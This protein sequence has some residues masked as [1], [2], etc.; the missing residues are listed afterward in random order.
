MRTDIRGQDDNYPT[1]PQSPLLEDGTQAAVLSGRCAPRITRC[2]VLPLLEVLAFAHRFASLLVLGTLLLPAP[3]IAQNH[4]ANLRQIYVVSEAVAR[5]RCEAE[6]PTCCC[7]YSCDVHGGNHG[8]LGPPSTGA[9]GV[10]QDC[11]VGQQFIWDY[12]FPAA[13]CRAGETFEPPYPGHCQPGPTA[14]GDGGK[15]NGN[16]NGVGNPCNP[17]TGNK[18]QVESD[19]KGNGSLAFTRYYNSQ[20][21]ADAG[22]GFG[23][24]ST[25]HKR[26]EVSGANVIV[27]QVTG[28]G[29]PFACPTSGVCAGD[30]DTKLSLN[31]DATGY[32]LIFGDGAS[33]RYDT[34]GRILLDT[35]RPGNS[36]TYDYEAGY[37]KSVIG[38]FGHTLTF[39][40]DANGHINSMTDS[41]EGLYTYEYDANNNLVRVTYPDTTFRIYHYEDAAHTHHLTGITDE[42]GIRFATFAYD[43]NGKA[44]TTEHAGHQERFTLQ[45]DSD[46]QTT[47]T[48]AANTEEVMTFAETLGFK[49][50]LSRINQTDNK[51]ITHEFDA[52]NN[53]TRAVDAEG[54]ETR[55][56]YNA[57]NQRL[58]MIEAVNT[59][60]ERTT[61][62]TYV[63]DDIDLPTE[64]VTPSVAPGQVK[65]V[66]TIYDA[67]H[68]PVEITQTGFTPNGISIARTITLRYNAKGQVIKI[69]GPRT[70]V[71][72]ITTLEYYDC[73]TG[74][75]CGQ[76]KSVTNALGHKT[77][78]DAYDANGQ[79]TQMTD[80]KGVV[81]TIT[82]D[83]RGRVTS[84][85]L[86]PPTG[87]ARITSYTYDGVGQLRT[88]T[89]PDGIILTYEY[90]DAHDLH[91][92][93]DNLHNRIEYAY[94]LRGN[95]T[96]ENTYDPD[97]TLVRSVHNAYDLRNR[98]SEINAAGSITQLV[99]DAVGNLISKTDPNAN[100]PTTHDYNALNRLQ[101]TV[102]ALGGKTGYGYDA[103]NRLIQVRAPNNA[104]TR[105]SYDDLGNLLEE[106]SPDRGTLTYT[107]DA[108]G[109][110]KSQ[111]DARGI[112]TAY[113]YDA[114]NRVIFIDDPGIE[115][116]VMFL[117]DA[118]PNGTGRLC[119]VEDQSG[120]TNY[121]YDAFG[122]V[123]QETHIELGMSYVTTYTYDA[124]DRLLSMTYPGGRIVG[125]TRDALGRV[126][127]V[128]TT[129]EG[130][131]TSITQAMSYR[132]DGLLTAQI[133]SNGLTE[134]RQ[135]DQQ[136]RLLSQSL[137][138]ADARV[139]DHDANGNLVSKQ[140]VLS[141]GSYSYDAL[142]RLTDETMSN[143][144][145]DTLAYSY[146]G[147]GNRLTR[148]ENGATEPYSYAA[149]SNRLTAI[150]GKGVTLDDA[151]NTL[152]DAQDRIFTY[153][154]TGRLS[155]VS[156]NGS[157]LGSYSYNFQGQ[158]TR[159]VTTRGTILYHYD[160]Q[161]NLIEETN[162][163]GK[164][165]SEYIW[166]NGAPIAASL[167]G[168]APGVYTFSGTDAGTGN[169]ATVDLDTEAR[170]VTVNESGGV[171]TTFQPTRWELNDTAQTL[172]ISYQTN[173]NTQ[174]N[175]SFALAES[176]PTGELS[177][178]STPRRAHYRFP[179]QPS[180]VLTGGDPANG[181][182]AILA[183]DPATR[184]VALTEHGTTRTLT[185][186]QGNW[187][188][189]GF[190]RLRLTLF[191]Y[192][193]TGFRL[194]G[195]VLER[196][197]Q[198]EGWVGLTDGTA[199]EARYALTGE[200]ASAARF[201]YLHTDHLNTPRVATDETQTVLWRWEGEAFGATAPNEDADGDHLHLTLNLR[202]PGQYADT[203]SG[204]YYN[205][206][207]YYDS[208]SGRYITSDPTG[209]FAA[210]NT[211]LY[212]RGNPHQLI[213][214]IGLGAIVGRL[215]DWRIRQLDIDLGSPFVTGDIA[216]FNPKK[217]KRRIGWFHFLVSG[218]V[219][220]LIECKEVECEQ[221][222]RRG[223]LVPS[224]SVEN[225]PLRLP[226]R[227]DQPFPLPVWLKALNGLVDVYANRNKAR[228]ILQAAA[229]ARAQAATFYCKTINAWLPVPPDWYLTEPSVTEGS[230]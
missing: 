161:G 81:T 113:S 155:Q 3:A 118:C 78:Y 98:L 140:T 128:T 83:A 87:S 16:C 216:P 215:I 229:F 163:Q 21:P 115:Q 206:M 143:G 191:R 37:L 4:A 154:T 120:T 151:G 86:T 40:H 203:E 1:G 194:L 150:D 197:T 176:P 119:A 100:P 142:D 199:R 221:E 94:D 168:I 227:E 183:L 11:P 157:I 72:D 219:D 198:A 110:L 66:T 212:V 82:Y 164:T 80:P 144:T 31:A 43:S 180:G 213:D 24:T 125:Y 126:T 73:A 68:N 111:T 159:K 108:A 175:A 75:E 50:L 170:T 5:E 207:R 46:T 149:G 192:D 226:I 133:F 53:L 173:G 211:F 29:E 64:I 148:S 74:A 156:Q 27:R 85:T 30:V 181:D 189:V 195:L 122:N 54:R 10:D 25:V 228:A 109:N 45:Y 107:Y 97:G 88:A 60:E 38:P 103:N 77:T 6:K 70:D 182:S 36:V 222:K 135:Y 58:T 71:E 153:N 76:L 55:Y 96:Q 89:T 17:A 62:Y 152:T 69:D 218:D 90:T 22:M 56:A 220:L 201:V 217:L 26:L 204:L 137:G 91:A 102:D 14:G 214:P 186:P 167:Q 84:L 129:V 166:A 114:L 136:G 171:N 210:L 116:D 160:L 123:T 147:N 200:A 141:V 230:P 177:L 67:I 7:F 99:S 223:F 131:T 18:Y 224:I 92:I 130:Q 169:A 35:D 12:F 49:N 52:Q 187:F 190:G 33:E 104:T 172:R 9:I 32:T 47:V 57:N 93:T 112:T 145:L 188:S 178:S 95:R 23:W 59:P 39:T 202:F 13:P 179:S 79:V 184:S 138:T 42:N 61:T 196:G 44:I 51:G 205:W 124:G 162:A 41:A 8:G 101:Q 2:R 105:Y 132:A 193:T 19:Y 117:Y 134:T 63:S 15:N 121:A 34:S 28:R 185:I 48:D 208:N 139:Y 209:T 165:L 146:D 127:E 158:R 174:I 65:H 225:L 106:R 20:F